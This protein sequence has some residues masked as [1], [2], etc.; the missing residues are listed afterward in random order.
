[1][2][3]SGDVIPWTKLSS[4]IV[5]TFW[6]YWLHGH[7]LYNEADAWPLKNIQS[8]ETLILGNQKRNSENIERR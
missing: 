7:H 2:L 6:V 4:N 5:R 8:L 1:M 3:S